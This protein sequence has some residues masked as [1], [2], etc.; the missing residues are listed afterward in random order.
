M[1][2]HLPFALLETALATG[3]YDGA[4]EGHPTPLAERKTIENSLLRARVTLD[5]RLPAFTV[6]LGELRDLAPGMVLNTRIPTTSPVEVSVSGQTRFTA[7]AGRKGHELAIRILEST[8]GGF[9]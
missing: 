8:D 6:A 4:G 9:R 7:T 2:A 1:H 5:A 3:S